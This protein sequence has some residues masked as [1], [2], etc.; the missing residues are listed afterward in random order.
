MARAGQASA[1]GDRGTAHGA[2]ELVLPESLAPFARGFV[3][4]L[5]KFG[6]HVHE[7]GWAEWVVGVVGGGVEYQRVGC[8]DDGRGHFRGLL[9]A[10]TYASCHD[11]TD[12]ISQTEQP[13]TFCA[14][15]GKL[16][17]FRQ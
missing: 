5:G 13:S 4:Q 12:A 10:C 11:W 14:G 17:S 16:G 1:L 15:R 3:V 2:G 9:P 7:A 8:V 6:E